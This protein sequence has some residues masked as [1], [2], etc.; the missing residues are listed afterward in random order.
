MWTIDIGIPISFKIALF[1][2]TQVVPLGSPTGGVSLGVLHRVCCMPPGAGTVVQWADPP[3]LPKVNSDAGD[4]GAKE[5]TKGAAQQTV[6]GRPSSSGKLIESPSVSY[7]LDG[8]FKVFDAS[9]MEAKMNRRRRTEMTSRK[10]GAIQGGTSTNSR[11]TAVHH[12]SKNQADDK[13]SID[14]RLQKEHS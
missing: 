11:S 7:R 1:P 10:R 6:K 4:A 3:A 9:E 14:R 13:M 8:Q 2:L 5:D 12:S